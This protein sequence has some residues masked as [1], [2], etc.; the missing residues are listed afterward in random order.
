MMMYRPFSRSATYLCSSTHA[1]RGGGWG[2]GSDESGG[3]C[4]SGGDGTKRAGC[5]ACYG[6]LCE[7]RQQT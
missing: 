2:H 7:H 5:E 1:G 3:A 6:R 4:Q